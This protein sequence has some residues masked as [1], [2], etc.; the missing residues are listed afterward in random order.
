MHKVREMLAF[1]RNQKWYPDKRA[2]KHMQVSHFT[3]LDRSRSLQKITFL[4][5]IFSLIQDS[6]IYH[7]NQRRKKNKQHPNPLESFIS[8]HML[9]INIG[10][11]HKIFKTELSNVLFA[12][13]KF[14]LIFHSKRLS[15]LTDMNALVTHPWCCGFVFRL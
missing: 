10:E 9:D 14:S 2:G 13:Q 4:K 12:H 3:E 8:S 1:R 6:K 15:Q 11:L 7:T 5:G